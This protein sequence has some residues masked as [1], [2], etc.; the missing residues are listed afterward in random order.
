MIAGLILLG[1][2]L[3]NGYH[4]MIT[5]VAWGMYVFG[6]MVTT[7]GLNAYVLDG[8][9]EVSIIPIT[10]HHIPRDSIVSYFLSL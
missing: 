1:F 7:V 3:E 4:F 6:I 5:S 8:Y 10:F 2:A 9:P